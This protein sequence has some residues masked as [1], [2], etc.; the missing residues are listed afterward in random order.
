MKAKFLKFSLICMVAVGLMG[1]GSQNNG[2]DEA[3]TNNT[4]SSEA[5]EEVTFDTFVQALKQAGGDLEM[6]EDDKPYFQLIGADDGWMLDYNDKVAKVYLYEDEK[7][8][9]EALKSNDFMKDFIKRDKL[10]LETSS[11]EVKEIFNSMDPAKLAESI[12][13]DKKKQDAIYKVGETAV[14]DNWEITLNTTSF[15]QSVEDS[16]F[17]SSADEGNKFLVLNL[18]VK[19]NGTTAEHFTYLI[20]GVNVKAYYNEKYEYNSVLTSIDGDLSSSSVE[21]LASSEGFVVIEM[22]DSVVEAPESIVVEMKQNME[23]ISWGIR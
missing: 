1:C 23:K 12:E 21:P 3:S 16:F 17:S 9:K 7:A 6:Y 15:E 10:T 5:Q 22:P 14:L 19:N 11:D 18:S 20:D 2:G 8:Y 13:E 4:A